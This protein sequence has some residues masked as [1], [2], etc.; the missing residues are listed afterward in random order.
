M[1]PLSGPVRLT[2]ALTKVART[3]EKYTSIFSLLL[4]AFPDRDFR[5]NLYVRT[6][7]SCRKPE[8]SMEHKYEA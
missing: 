5:V 3:E 6:R 2:T 4:L 7:S 8:D 1:K